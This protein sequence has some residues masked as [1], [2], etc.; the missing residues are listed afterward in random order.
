MIIDDDEVCRSIL[1]HY[2]KKTDNLS[3]LH[4]SGDAIEGY[5][6][7]KKE[8]ENIDIL[9][10]DVEMPE[11]TGLDIV[12]TMEQDTKKYIIITTSREQYAVE[13]FELNI[14]DY[15]LKPINYPRFIKAIE[16]I[17]KKA[18]AEEAIISEETTETKA[19]FVRS[20]HSIIKIVPQEICFVEAFADYLLV[21][22]Q[23]PNFMPNIPNNLPNSTEPH[24]KYMVHIS[25]KSLEEKLEKYKYL[26]RV[27]RS[28]MVNINKLQ[29]IH[30]SQ[31]YIN[32]EEIPIGRNYKQDFLNN[33]NIL[34]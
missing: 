5:N 15:L 9:F 33:L 25:L 30:D 4:S 32:G 8:G 11:M 21:Y 22:T 2:I 16:K 24:L 26:V 12:R 1:S 3:L 23:N 17:Q 34:S 10:L 14:D 31:V 28:Y 29:K 6:I 7:L 27:H 19:F 20:Q 13:A 18:T